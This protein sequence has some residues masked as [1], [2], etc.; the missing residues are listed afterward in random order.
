ME[1]RRWNT[2]CLSQKVSAATRNW[3]EQG[4]NALQELPGKKKKEKKQS[5]IFTP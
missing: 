2:A 5:L 1:T 3:K 4:T